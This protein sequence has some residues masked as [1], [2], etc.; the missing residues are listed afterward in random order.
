MGNVIYKAVHKAINWKNRLRLKNKKPSIIAS[1]CTGGF[2]YHWLGL[3]FRSPF[4]NL[5]L[6]NESFVTML[7]NWGKEDFSSITETSQPRI[8]YPVAMAGGG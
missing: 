5:W 4:I 2:I 7:E 3:Q 6:D 8:N 1:Q